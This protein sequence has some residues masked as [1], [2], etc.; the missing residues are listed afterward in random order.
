MPKDDGKNKRKKRAQRGCSITQSRELNYKGS[1]RNRTNRINIQRDF[2][3]EEL[4]RVI[5]GAAGMSETSGAGQQAGNP[6]RISMFL[7]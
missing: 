5:V 7:S 1:Q 4:A 6:S 2:Y 3:F